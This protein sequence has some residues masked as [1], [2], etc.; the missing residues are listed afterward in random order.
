MVYYSRTS[1]GSHRHGV[2]VI[3]G[4]EVAKQEVEEMYGIMTDILEKLPGEDI[5]IV[6]GDFN[7]KI[8]RGA[9][10]EAVGPFGLRERNERSDRLGVFCEEQRL[11]VLNTF[12]RML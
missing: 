5:N 10:G 3:L 7:A 1:D 4:G 2:G 6:M 12:F 8:G 9:S 11:T